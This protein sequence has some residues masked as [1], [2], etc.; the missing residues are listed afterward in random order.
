MTT[1]LSTKFQKFDLK[2]IQL[3][4]LRKFSK[5][6]LLGLYVVTDTFCYF[7]SIFIT[8][9]P[10]NALDRRTILG[11]C[12]PGFQRQVSKHNKFLSDQRKL[13]GNRRTKKSV[14]VEESAYNSQ[15]A[16][17]GLVMIDTRKSRI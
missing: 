17:F 10:K 8:T 7:F 15:N 4:F 12:V 1:V 2:K 5:F 16:Q 9:K 3:N 6:L 11:L 14:L 13:K